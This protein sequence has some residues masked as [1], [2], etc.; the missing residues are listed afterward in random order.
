MICSLFNEIIF[1]GYNPR[2]STGLLSPLDNK[3]NSSSKG[4]FV[5]KFNGSNNYSWNLGSDY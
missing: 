1:L 4:F 2:S 3:L 5:K